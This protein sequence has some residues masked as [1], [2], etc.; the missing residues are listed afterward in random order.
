[1]TRVVK[2]LVVVLDPKTIEENV[3]GSWDYHLSEFSVLLQMGG[4]AVLHIFPGFLIYTVYIITSGKIVAAELSPYKT[5][6][7]SQNTATSFH[8]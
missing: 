6:S 2:Q 4:T 7:Q 5:V 8:F 1:M 3:C